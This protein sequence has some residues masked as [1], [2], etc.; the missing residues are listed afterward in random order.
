MAQLRVLCLVDTSPLTPRIPQLSEACPPVGSEAPHFLDEKKMRQ[1]EA[2]QLVVEL[3]KIIKLGEKK[4]VLLKIRL[5]MNVQGV[6]LLYNRRSAGAGGLLVPG[7]LCQACA[8]CLSSPC[9]LQVCLWLLAA[10][11]TSARTPA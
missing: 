4:T 1:K 9:S 6:A 7:P 10:C 8:C 11:S 2:A 3:W 5:G